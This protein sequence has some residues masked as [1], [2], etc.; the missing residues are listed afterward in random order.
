MNVLKTRL[1]V[2]AGAMMA[3]TGAVPAVAQYPEQPIRIVVPFPAGGLTDTYARMFARNLTEQL[4]QP[5]IVENVAG[6]TGQIG[7]DR[8]ARAAP[9]GYTLLYTSSSAQ[10][11]A[12]LM[13]RKPAFD[14]VKDFTPI[15]RVIEYPVV[16]YSHPGLP[17]TSATELVALARSRGTPMTCASVGIG[18]VGHLACQQF[19]L[20][21]R[22]ELLHVPY[23]G[24]A[25]AQMAVI[26]GE[27]DVTFDSVG[28]SQKM[29]DA[30]K[31]RALAVLGDRRT[32][33]A[34]NVPTVAE[35]GLPAVSAYVWTGVLG[36]AGLPRPIQIKLNEALAKALKSPEFSARMKQDGADN[37]A[38]SPAEFAE[39]IRQEQ[40]QWRDV[41]RVKNLQID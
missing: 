4:A 28:G 1:V 35:A 8:V 22:I 32:D 41:I 27:A 11:L 31:L 21:N 6:A 17:V 33:G 24:A 13:A 25:P 29:A 3:I 2:A 18:S 23:K 5:V 12:P 38:G 7:S 19:A 15:T 14:P 34:P 26:S 36:P 30:G 39:R 16:L 40:A 37:A 9:D 20:A 10:V